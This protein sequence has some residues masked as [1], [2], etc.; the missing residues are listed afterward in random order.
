[1]SCLRGDVKK[2]VLLA[3]LRFGQTPSP[4]LNG[5]V[6]QKVPFL[7]QGTN[8]KSSKSIFF[9]SRIFNY[10]FQVSGLATIT[11]FCMH[12][13][14]VFFGWNLKKKLPECLFFSFLSYGS[15]YKPNE[16]WEQRKECMQISSTDCGIIKVDAWHF[17]LPAP[18]STRASLD[19]GRK[20]FWKY[21]PAV[22]RAAC[23]SGS[24]YA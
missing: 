5:A 6:S 20:T 19:P 22:V 24:G 17:N 15:E 13:R 10:F 2:G 21:R 18:Y 8:L 11:N 7:S 23:F 1:M 9:V 4:G 3:E 16:Q 12:V 14:S